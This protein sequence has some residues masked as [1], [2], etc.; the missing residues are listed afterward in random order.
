MKRFTIRR[1]YEELGTRGIMYDDSSGARVCD[2]IERPKTGDHACIPEGTYTAHRFN[3]PKHGPGIWQLESVHD[4]SNI[5][6]HV[7]NWPHELLGCIA[8]GLSISTGSNGEPGVSSSRIA[9]HKFM[10]MTAYD[11]EIKVTF[12]SEQ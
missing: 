5:Q 9:F 11:E 10:G 8:P 4:R 6:I 7:A 12:T 1:T 2:T 3:S